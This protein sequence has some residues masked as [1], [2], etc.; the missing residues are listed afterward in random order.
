[1]SRQNYYIFLSGNTLS[2]GD[3]KM[4]EPKKNTPAIACLK[5][6]SSKARTNMIEIVKL[7]TSG[8]NNWPLGTAH[9]I[10]HFT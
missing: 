8:F 1:M 7:E 2:L 4:V 10:I 3:A 5:C 9:Q 6:A